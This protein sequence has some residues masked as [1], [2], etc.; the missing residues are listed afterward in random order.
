MVSRATNLIEKWA[1][2]RFADPVEVWHVDELVVEA[3]TRV[4]GQVLALV[5]DVRQV[6]ETPIPV[7]E[8]SSDIFH[9]K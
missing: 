1:R 6:T 4:G 8:S 5:E 3:E 7:K 9:K 2:L